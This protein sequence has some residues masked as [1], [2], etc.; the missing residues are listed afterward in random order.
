MKADRVDHIGEGTVMKHPQRL[1]PPDPFSS[2]QSFFLL[3][4][5]LP[6]LLPLVFPQEH[7]SY[8]ITEAELS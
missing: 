3:L 6:L 4:L 1:D 5:K 7:R 2:A 8:C